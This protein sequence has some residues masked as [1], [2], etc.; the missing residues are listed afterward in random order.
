MEDSIMTN[1]GFFL[2]R[3]ESNIVILIEL[4]QYGSG[5]S[6]GPKELDPWGKYDWE[7]VQAYAQEH[8]E[9]EVEWSEEQQ[10]Y[11]TVQDPV[12]V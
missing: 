9:M 11:I 2:I 8:P 6:C 1:F 7:E 5:Y 3:N 4:D 10:K 12:E